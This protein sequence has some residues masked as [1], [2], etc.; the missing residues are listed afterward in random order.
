MNN[1]KWKRNAD[2]GQKVGHYKIEKG[3]IS[4]EYKTGENQELGAPGMELKE[5]KSP[6][7]KATGK[8]YNR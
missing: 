6:K 2:T 8:A 5:F 4:G 1:R 7:H 3:R